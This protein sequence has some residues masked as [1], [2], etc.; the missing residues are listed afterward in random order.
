MSH[1]I[2][3]LDKL[4]HP[5][6]VRLYEVVESLAKLYLIMEYAGSTELHTKIA[7]EGR[8]SETDAKGT[9]TQVIAAVEYMVGIV[10]CVMACV[11]V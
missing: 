5:N 10:C 1:E 3:S 9:M 7:D 2:T 11:R 8:M 6:I 4:W